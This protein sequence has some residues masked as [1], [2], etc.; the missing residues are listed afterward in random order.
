MTDNEWY[1]CGTKE[2]M[3]RYLRDR[4]LLSNRKQVLLACASIG[5]AFSQEPYYQLAARFVDGLATTADLDAAQAALQRE[6]DDDPNFWDRCHTTHADEVFLRQNLL[7]IACG[8]ESILEI[9]TGGLSSNPFSPSEFSEPQACVGVVLLHELFGNPFRTVTLNPEWLSR[10]KNAGLNLA[11]RIYEEANFAL[12]PALATALAN[13]GC[14]NSYI[15]D[16]CRRSVLH[17]R[18]CWVLDLLLGKEV[19]ETSPFKV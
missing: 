4:G 9:D 7:K 2:P 18:G 15:F 8:K 10:N 19:L 14:D 5:P 6:A 1:L 16:H 12:M 11:K 17:T 13:A 3:L